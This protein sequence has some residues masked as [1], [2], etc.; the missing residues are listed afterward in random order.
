MIEYNLEVEDIELDK[1]KEIEKKERLSN[2]RI[3]CLETCIKIVN[4]F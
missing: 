3:K 2:N 4:F 1:L